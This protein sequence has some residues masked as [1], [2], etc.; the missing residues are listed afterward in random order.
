[1]KASVTSEFEGCADNENNFVFG[2][3]CTFPRRL[4]EERR[5]QTDVLGQFEARR[6]TEQS[7]RAVLSVGCDVGLIDKVITPSMSRYH[8]LLG[9]TF[10]KDGAAGMV[11]TLR[12]VT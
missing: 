4:I 3:D 12:S 8:C 5:S 9:T 1:M 10:K 7:V 11:T 2:I 6:D